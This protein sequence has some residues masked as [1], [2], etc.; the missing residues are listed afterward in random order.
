MINFQR[1]YGEISYDPEPRPRPDW[2]LD[3]PET[4]TR[5]DA[6][7]SARRAFTYAAVIFGLIG[8]AAG[9]AWGQVPQ[10]RMHLEGAT[11]DCFAVVVINNTSGRYNSDEAL[12]TTRGTVVLRYHTVGGHNATDADEVTVVSLPDG[13]LADPE[14]MALPDGETGR[15]CLIRFVGM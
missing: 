9:A 3:A 8:F 5:A 10:T 4:V 11:G 15:V 2:V 14:F 13:V 7:A 1:G 6:N 12:D